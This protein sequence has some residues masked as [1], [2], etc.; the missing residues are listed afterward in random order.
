MSYVR[1]ALFGRVL[2]ALFLGGIGCAQA[3]EIK[4]DLTMPYGN[5]P[6]WY[7]SR[8]PGAP[9]WTPLVLPKGGA[10]HE[11][12]LEGGARY[13]LHDEHADAGAFYEIAILLMAANPSWDAFSGTWKTTSPD[14]RAATIEGQA[15]STLRLENEDVPVPIHVYMLARDAETKKFVTYV[16]T[17]EN[18][19]RQLREKRGNFRVTLTSRLDDWTCVGTSRSPTNSERDMRNRGDLLYGCSTSRLLK[20]FTKFEAYRT[21]EKALADV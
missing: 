10:G 17:K 9:Q 21:A 7:C 5:V 6:I 12:P 1:I 11:C 18:L 13:N 3:F 19:A 20:Y 15:A 4:W 8:L 14:L 16:F 2:W